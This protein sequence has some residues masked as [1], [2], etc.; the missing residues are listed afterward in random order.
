MNLSDSLWRWRPAKQNAAVTT[1]VFFLIFF[2][3]SASIGWFDVSIFSSGH[4]R[5]EQILSDPTRKESTD[6]RNGISTGKEFLLNCCSRINQTQ[7]C[8]GDYPTTH[9]PTNLGPS[10]SCPSY[11]RWIYESLRPWKE[12][13]ISKDMVEQAR[14]YAHIGMVILNGKAHAVTYGK[15]VFQTRDLFT[16]WGILQLL[17]RYPGRLPDMELVFQLGDLSVVRKQKFLGPNARPPP[18]FRYCSDDYSL[19]IVFP[20]WT[21]WGWAE[22]NIRPWKNMLEGIKE[23]SKRMKWEDREP[24]AFW[25]GNPYVTPD[26]SRI[27]LLKCNVSK[28]HDWNTRLYTQDWKKESQQGFKHSNLEDQCIHRYK[29]YIEGQAWS[30]SEKYI[31]ACDSMTLFVKPRYF[32]FF[33]RELLPLQHYWP[34]N[35]N[36]KCTSL[37]FAVEWGNTHP[38]K[39]KAIGKAAVKF[40]EEDLKMDYVYDYMFHL[41]TEYAKLLKFKPQVPEGA[42]ELCAETMAC[43]QS[44][45]VKKFMVE[46]LVTSPSHTAPCAMPPPY[47]AVELREF[48]ERKANATRQV[49]TWEKEYQ[50]KI[51]LKKEKKQ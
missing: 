9:N 45:N 1:V 22:T 7:T 6:C 28:K 49:G 36:A 51:N 30:V 35:N 15:K 44:G 17:R 18:L 42:V 31:M 14:K 4:N 11:F 46:S 3:V 34:I 21:F 29:I 13:G 10:S 40:M 20:D 32:D 47:D 43:G 25:K 23:G 39:A 26:N 48:L 12:I 33:S 16:L 27:D 19:D 37:K 50:R 8:P 2:C 5:H 24:Y 38:E 41:L